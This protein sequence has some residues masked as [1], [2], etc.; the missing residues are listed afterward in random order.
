M[1]VENANSLN[2]LKD[3]DWI[4]DS[5]FVPVRGSRVRPNARAGD[6]KQAGG[7]SYSSLSFA[8]TTPGGNGSFGAKP[9]FTPFADIHLPSFLENDE[10]DGRNKN[11]KSL[12][13]GRSYAET[14]DANAQRIYMQFGTPVYNSLTNYLTSFYDSG[15]GNMVNTGRVDTGFFYTAGKFA[16]FIFFWSVVPELCILN[17]LYS[18]SRKVLADIQHAPMYKFYYMQPTMPLYWSTVQTIVNAIAVNMG[19]AQPV[20]PDS[21][22]RNVDGSKMAL[23]PGKFGSSPENIKELNR[24]LPDVFLD[25]NGGLDVRRMAGRYQRK[26]EAHAGVMN[27]IREKSNTAEE[28]TANMQGYLNGKEQLAKVR[29]AEN[30]SKKMAT[31][32][33]EYMQSVAGTGLH[34]IDQLV[35]FVSGSNSDPA[36]AP[37]TSV[38]DTKKSTA[39]AADST[40]LGQDL[41]KLWDG[42]RQQMLEYGDFALGELMDGSAFASF[43]VEN[44]QTVRESFSNSSRSSDL[45]EKINSTSREA[46]SNFFN[47]ANGNLGDGMIMGTLETVTSAVSS[48][49]K[50]V[51][52]SVG[53]SGLSALGGK[54]F[55][56]IPD[57]WDGSETSLPTASY[58]MELRTPYG[59]PISILTNIIIPLAML[60]A[61]FAPRS[62]G[63]NSYSGPFLCKLW[64]KGKVQKQLALPKSL[65]ITRGT[66]NVGW[67]INKQ[68]LAIDVNFEVIDL[69]K[70]LHVPITT[71]LRWSDLIPGKTMFDEDNNFTD[72]MAVLGSLG[73]SEQY[74]ATDRWRLRRATTAQN[75]ET[76]LSPEHLLQWA[77]GDTKVGSVMSGIARGRRTF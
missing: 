59:N 51:V 22:Q 69:S 58:T 72:Y 49:M 36:K 8:D 3:S 15:H 29:K 23:D 77:I 65:S 20:A 9:Q 17:L 53:F 14:I 55:A 39:S 38:S 35:D 73:L 68:P 33:D 24:I 4:R 42:M 34:L 56:D 12:G 13:M 67:S 30:E 52:D 71:E 70:M 40:T 7:F 61:A 1:S 19:L 21:M 10:G 45:A 47:V 25:E 66:G 37:D 63:R 50:G 74:Y 75:F 57:F 16:G 5:F 60:I 31:Y 44:E 2:E 43:I 54:A 6:M 18:T 28:F 11:N 41:T 62:T 64:E 76:F 46:R 32:M 27:I 26:S 48:L